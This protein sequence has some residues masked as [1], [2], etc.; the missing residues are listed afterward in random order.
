MN[1]DTSFEPPAR[2]TDIRRGLL[3][4]MLQI[5]VSILVQTT[6]LIVSSGRLDWVAA[7]AYVGVNVAVPVVNSLIIL[8]KN[9]ELI[10]E[11]AQ[12]KETRAWDRAIIPSVTLLLFVTLIVAGLDNRFGWSPHLALAIQFFAL[13]LVVLGYGLLSWAMLSNRFFS[14]VVRIQKERGHIVVTA[15]P[16]QYVRHPG[17]AGMI[18]A[19]LATPILLGS[20]WALVP[21]GLAVCGYVVRTALEDRTLREELDG[22]KDYARRVRYRLVP[23]IW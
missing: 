5:V 2:K 9:P 19:L 10:A 16:Y 8:P 6:V 3:K 21:A 14:G 23:G 12:I 17:Y 11:R 18:T 15:G 1:D 4:R 22:Y 20:L 13:A 7:W